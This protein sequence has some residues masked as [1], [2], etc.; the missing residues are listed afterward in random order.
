MK[1]RI[2]SLLVLSM[3]L[4]MSL[5]ACGA[6]NDVSKVGDLGKSFMT[7]LQNNDATSS[8]GMLTTTVQTQIGDSTA[9]EAFV[10][11]RNFS[12][13]SFSNTQ[14]NNNTGQMDGIA[15]LG[16]DKYTVALVFEKADD[17]WL[18]SGIN[19]TKQ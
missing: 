5:S 17:A 14:V 18:I 11:P 6:I 10:A 15:T 3:V 19:F 13:F 12:E 8:W 1:K 9:W 7:A 4:V 16:A 2:V